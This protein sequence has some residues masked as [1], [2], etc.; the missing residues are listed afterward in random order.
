MCNNI[1]HFSLLQQ[2][3]HT[4]SRLATMAESSQQDTKQQLH[5][6]QRQLLSERDHARYTERK[7]SRLRVSARQCYDNLKNMFMF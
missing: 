3:R 2:S 4:L 5:E 6:L 1:V 7:Y